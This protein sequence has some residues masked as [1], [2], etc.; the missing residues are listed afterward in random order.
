MLFSRTD[1]PETDFLRYEQMLE[2]K[3]PRKIP[4]CVVCR[5]IITE[6]F[7]YDIDGDI[8]CSD[9]LIEHHMKWTEDYDD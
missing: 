5:K 2:E 7:Y 6:D 8:L 1:D 3:E 4:R 9:C